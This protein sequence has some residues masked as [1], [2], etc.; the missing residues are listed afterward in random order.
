MRLIRL[1]NL[2]LGL[3]FLAFFI[4]YLGVFYK[5]ILPYLFGLGLLIISYSIG[6]YFRVGAK[7]MH[8]KKIACPSCGKIT[9]VYGQK[10]GCMHCYSPIQL[11]ENGQLMQ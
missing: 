4:M 3:M 7:S 10:D 6:I 9:R 11:D 5:P 2:A 1:R 8:I